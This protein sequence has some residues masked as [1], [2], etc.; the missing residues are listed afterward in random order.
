[1]TAFGWRAFFALLVIVAL[2]S[3]ASWMGLGR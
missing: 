3:V 1:M 2:A